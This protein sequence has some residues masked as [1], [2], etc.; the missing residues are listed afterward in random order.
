M[1]QG[2]SIFMT[3]FLYYQDLVPQDLKK[4]RLEAAKLQMRKFRWFMRIVKSGIQ[5]MGGQF[6]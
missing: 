5:R 3:D 2:L 1:R 6:F 4:L